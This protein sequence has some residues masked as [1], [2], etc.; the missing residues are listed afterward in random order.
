MY[1]FSYVNLWQRTLWQKLFYYL[2]AL[3]FSERDWWR[4][5]MLLPFSINYVHTRRGV[6]V[7]FRLSVNL[8]LWMKSIT[9]ES[10]LIM[11]EF[12]ALNFNLDMRWFVFSQWS[13]VRGALLYCGQWT[14]RSAWNSQVLVN[15]TFQTHVTAPNVGGWAVSTFIFL[16]C[17]WKQVT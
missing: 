4:V 3:C 7:W 15:G 2:L 17:I 10:I 1:I 14:T 6:A 13:L 9:D 8:N 11:D 5:L 12:I 16:N